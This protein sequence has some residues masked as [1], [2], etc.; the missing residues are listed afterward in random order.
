MKNYIDQEIVG[1]SIIKDQS[2]DNTKS[3]RLSQE[4]AHKSNYD[5]NVYFK[6]NLM[7]DMQNE[8][9]KSK[10]EIRKMLHPTLEDQYLPNTDSAISGLKS[11]VDSMFYPK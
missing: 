3:R 9:C 4:S 6:L 10:K 7:R 1:N 8:K 2:K 5:M 11:Q